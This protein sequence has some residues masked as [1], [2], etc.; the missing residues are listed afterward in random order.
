MNNLYAQ[1]VELLL[2]M[3]PIISEE[4]VF[5]VHGGS[6]INLFINDMPRY[7]IDADL[8]YIPLEDR[9]TSIDNINSHLNAISE[10]AKK[11]SEECI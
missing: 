3:I 1:K 10:K 2:R 4:G 11:H 8:T 5:A 7:S 9:K 6:A